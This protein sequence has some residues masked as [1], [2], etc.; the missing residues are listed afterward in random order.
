MN[1]DSN[2][3]RT[4][5]GDYDSFGG[6]LMV[7]YWCLIVGG[8]M[9]ILFT[10]LPAL[11]WFFGSF[12][13]GFMFAV[14]TLVSLASVVASAVFD[15]KAALQLKARNPKF[16]DTFL[17]GV[18]ISIGGTILS[19]LFQIN[20]IAGVGSFIGST[21][22]SLFGLAISLCLCLMYFSK[23]VRVLTY[24]GGR[25]VQRSRYWHLIKLLPPFVISD[26]MPD[27]GR[28]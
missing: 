28:R 11:I 25:P 7:W 14:G 5:S 13:N 24:F 27:I 12:V 19:S 22:A 23:S 3:N 6:W 2:W 18:L 4:N 15:I 20:G 26:T 8:A 9:M 16:F 17:H 10:G 21:I 1:G